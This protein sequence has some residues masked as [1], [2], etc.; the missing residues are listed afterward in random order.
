[1]D[2]AKITGHLVLVMGPTGSGKG[3]IIRYILNKFPNLQYSVSCTTRDMRTGEI[4]GKD[5]HF[6]SDEEFDKRIAADEFLEWA[7]FSAHK[8]GTLRKEITDR[9]ENGQVVITEIE[10]QGV[11]Q[12]LK[13]IPEMNRTLIF[14][15][16]G[17]WEV[18]KT[19]ALARAPMTPEHL[20]LRHAR[21]VEEVKSKPYA[22]VII[23]NTEGKL[24]EANGH[25]TK[26]IESIFSN[27]NQSNNHG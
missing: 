3:S 21:Y 10:L 8:Y 22:D 1:M 6:L 4:D 11:Q 24:D 18:L 26:V 19:R 5:Y 2:Q 7:V 14:I 12:L 13:I 23:D 25:M 27:I 15:E 9:L 16:A 17:D 20:E